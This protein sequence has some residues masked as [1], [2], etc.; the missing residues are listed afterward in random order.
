M[1]RRISGLSYVTL[2][3]DPWK[4]RAKPVGAKAK[5][6]RFERLVSKHLPGALHSQWFHFVDN[7]GP[8]HCCTDLLFTRAGVLWVAECKLTDWAEADDQINFLY[9]PVL[10]RL[11]DG[12]VRGVV[13]AK[14]LTPLTERSRVVGSWD[15]ALSH[16]SP[17]LHAPGARHLK[18]PRGEVCAP[19]WARDTFTY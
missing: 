10:E 3:E 2:T 1:A 9:K 5:G 18:A 14:Y 7:N 13:V 11:W 15:E 8:G 17:V 19:R 16:P 6:L 4:S 12:E